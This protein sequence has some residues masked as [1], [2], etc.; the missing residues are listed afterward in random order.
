MNEKPRPKDEGIMT[1]DFITGIGIEGLVIGINTI[2]AFYMGLNISTQ[3]ASTM[4][5]AT[6]CLSRLFHGF[7][8]KSERPVLFKKEMFNNKYLN[9]SF[10]IGFVLL[11]AVITC[12]IFTASI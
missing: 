5:F 6:L 10:I 12:T 8:S 4:A 9:G 11:N 3:A 2:I 7:N 1:K